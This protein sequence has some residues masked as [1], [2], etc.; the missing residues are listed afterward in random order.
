MRR[1]RLLHYLRVPKMLIASWTAFSAAPLHGAAATTDPLG[2]SGH[3]RLYKSAYFL[4]RGDTGISE[5]DNEDA[6]FY[7]PAGLA[8]GKGIFKEVVLASPMV[9]YSTAT[10]SLVRQLAVEDANTVDALRSQVGAPQHVGLNNFTGI[11]LRRVAIGGFVSSNTDILVSQS[12]DDG[13]L[14]HF[15]AS[16][17]E[18]AGRCSRSRTHF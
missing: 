7:N 9:E 18:N 14:E 3:Q 15:E 1:S 2:T 16:T 12:P 17:S 6:I 8:L 13:G 4:G 5:A 11:V 10:K